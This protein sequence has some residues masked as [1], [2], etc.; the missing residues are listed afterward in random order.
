MIR[1]IAVVSAC[2]FAS[3]VTGC[4]G[5]RSDADIDR[6][7]RD[8][9]AKASPDWKDVTFKRNT[10]GVVFVTANRSVSGTVYEF[11]VAGGASAGYGVSFKSRG[12]DW[13]GKIQF[14]GGKRTS[15]E[16]MT[17]TEAQMTPLLPLA[18]ELAGAVEKA[19]G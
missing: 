6:R 15:A 17:G 10:S 14:Q 4:S 8:D 5:G 9:L 2:L 11:S 1:L 19:V 12:G 13:I 16:K 7:L 3:F 18:D